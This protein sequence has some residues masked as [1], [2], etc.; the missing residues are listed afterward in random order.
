[1]VL[2]VS[3]ATREN[4][5]GEYHEPVTHLWVWEVPIPHCGSGGGRSLLG[6]DR[7]QASG[8][9]NRISELCASA[10]IDIGT[11]IRVVFVGNTYH[12]G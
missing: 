3:C 1:M 9:E 12:Y 4:L 11:N 8:I 6:R 7:L 10:I 5:Y 2:Y